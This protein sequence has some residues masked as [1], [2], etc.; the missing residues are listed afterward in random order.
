M[1]LCM[2]LGAACCYADEIDNQLEAYSLKNIEQI[3]FS[4]MG[5]EKAGEAYFSPD[6]KMIA[7]QAVPKGKKEYQIYVMNLK[8]RIPK[9]ISTGRGACTCAAFHPA[10]KKIMFAS[11]HEDPRLKNP[12]YEQQA[13]GYKRKNSNYSWQFTPYMNIYEANLMGARSE[14]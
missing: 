3:T 8:D 2:V 9:M 7:F 12:Q 13:P 11:S 6:G 14:R 10:G 4:S 1:L 5:F